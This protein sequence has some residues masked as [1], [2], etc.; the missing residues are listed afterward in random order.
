MKDHLDKV[1]FLTQD[2]LN[3][4]YEQAFLFQEWKR[5]LYN[6]IEISDGLSTPY[7]NEQQYHISMELKKETKYAKRKLLRE[8]QEKTEEIARSFVS[9]IVW[10]LEKKYNMDID[11]ECTDEMVK[12]SEWKEQDY[13]QEIIEQ[14]KWQFGNSDVDSIQLQQ[15]CDKIV[16]KEPIA[17]GRVLEFPSKYSHTWRSIGNSINTEFMETVLSVIIYQEKKTFEMNKETKRM[18]DYHYDEA[19]IQSITTV[20]KYRVYKNGKLTFTFSSA[21]SLEEFMKTL[22]LNQTK[23]IEK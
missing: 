17:N 7:F 22:E 16:A 20:E 6:M 1:T 8:L 10:Y 9:A 19:L 13:I 11:V 5:G 23:R 18:L 15:L 4:M 21:D 14:L 2:D 3:F 12:K